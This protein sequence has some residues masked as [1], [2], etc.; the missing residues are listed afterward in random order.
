MSL[1][2]W[3][4]QQEEEPNRLNDR[5]NR[6]RAE[7]LGLK[8]SL[9]G[10]ETGRLNNE[11]LRDVGKRRSKMKIRKELRALGCKMIEE[12]QRG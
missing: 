6:P 10:V 1:G 11:T 7:V 3:L 5:K 8:T 2:V 12:G 9:L 4:S